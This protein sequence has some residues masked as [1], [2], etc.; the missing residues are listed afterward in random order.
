MAMG[1]PVE[2]R[3]QVTSFK[4]I[5]EFM[6]H[7]ILSLTRGIQTVLRACLSNSLS[8]QQN[9]YIFRLA[10]L[11]EKSTAER[12]NILTLRPVFGRTEKTTEIA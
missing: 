2:I 7:Q 1:S 3:A 4:S 12:Q 5:T 11:K 8:Q 6:Q 10:A 9:G